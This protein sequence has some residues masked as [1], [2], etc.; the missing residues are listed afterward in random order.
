MNV[1][2]ANLLARDGRR[3]IRTSGPQMTVEAAVRMGIRCCPRTTEPS[4]P[5]AA[6]PSAVLGVNEV[7]T[8]EMASAFGTLAFAGQ[9]VQ[10]TPVV[11]ITTRDGEVIY[12]SNA[13][14]TQVG[15]TGDRPGGRR[16]PQGRRLRR[17][18]HGR[19]HRA[20][21]VRQDRDGA[22]RERRVVRRRDPPDRDGRLGR[23]PAG[24][25]P[26]VL[27]QRPDLDRLRR[28]VAGADLEGLHVRGH[29]PDAGEGVR[30]S[31]PRWSTSRS[32]ST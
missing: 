26:H 6:V 32:G 12:R 24:S 21:A 22:E 16:H 4:G 18:R 31:R 14:P 2:Y 30:R 23:V 17:H 29:L 11:S 15:R 9:H 19:E 10:P 25:D 27:R 13:R 7:S 28:H 8:L 5:L 20:A 1:A 3:Q